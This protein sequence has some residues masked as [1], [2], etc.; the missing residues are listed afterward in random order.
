MACGPYAGH[1]PS[2][3]LNFCNSIQGST[4]PTLGNP[5][6]KDQP[7]FDKLILICILGIKHCLTLFKTESDFLVIRNQ[8]W[9][10]NRFMMDAIL[11]DSFIS[12]KI[13]TSI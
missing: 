5:S 13:Y 9:Y 2:L 7:Y 10:F 1:A 12:L 3:A 4:W 8:S 6:L 11:K